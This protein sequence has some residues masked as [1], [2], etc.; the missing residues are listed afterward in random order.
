MPRKVE[1][2]GKVGMLYDEVTW[3]TNNAANLQKN[4]EHLIKM[5]PAVSRSAGI[6]GQ[7][8]ADLQRLNKKLHKILDAMYSGKLQN[9]EN[10]R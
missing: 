1:P 10:I 6:T 7:D 8:A 9:P 2:R 4:V 3:G 5:A